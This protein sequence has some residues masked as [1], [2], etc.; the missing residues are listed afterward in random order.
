MQED[1]ISGRELSGWLALAF[2]ELKR[3]QTPENWAESKKAIRAIA[4]RGHPALLPYLPAEI[5]WAK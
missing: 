5:R 1:T 2:G 3:L 4:E